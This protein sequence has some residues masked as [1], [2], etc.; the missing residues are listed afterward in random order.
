MKLTAKKRGILWTIL[1]ISMFQM[2]MVALSP[3]ISS[4]T[5]VFPNA[6]QLVAQMATTF[7]NLILVIVALF[8]GQISNAIGRRKMC[9]I[10]LGLFVIAAIGGYFCSVSVVMVYVWSALLG[11]GTG[12]F[13][14]S[15]SSMMVDYFEPEETAHIAGY[16]TSA[17]NLGGV[18]LSI[19]SGLAAN[20]RWNTSYLVYFFVLPVI[21]LC[22]KFLPKQDKSQRESEA[23]GQMQERGEKKK[24]PAFV[25]AVTAETLAFAVCYFAFSTNA[26]LLLSERNVSNTSVTG[27]ATGIFMLGGCIVGFLFNKIMSVMKK[28]T[29]VFAFVLLAVSYALIYF[30]PSMPAMMLGAFIG[31]GSLSIIF[32]YAL[33]RVGGK[34]DPAVTVTASAWI[35]SVGPNFGS[36]LSPLILT[37]LANG[38]GRS[39]CAFRFFLAAVLA[40]ILGGIVFGCHLKE[41]E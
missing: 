19:L 18:L 23:K 33:L 20:A 4:I 37:N 25:F 22:I 2:G 16:Q 3:V 15:I 12:L 10:G 14:P 30:V 40:V 24:M 38:M 28:N 26:S 41:K 34:V 13:V 39:D 11:A 36:F 31:G 9:I 7:L 1:G 21:I 17:V 35:L 5:V 6:S 29:D 8:S 27:L 32:P